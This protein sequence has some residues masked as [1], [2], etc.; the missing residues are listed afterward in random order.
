[1][2]T[3]II[4]KNEGNGK[5]AGYRIDNGKKVTMSC[6]DRKEIDEDIWRRYQDTKYNLISHPN[7]EYSINSID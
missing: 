2:R 7:G 1:M 5:I 3:K 6:D 4:I